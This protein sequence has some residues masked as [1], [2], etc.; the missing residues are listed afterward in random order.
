MR[1]PTLCCAGSL[2]IEEYVYCRSGILHDYLS[3]IHGFHVIQKLSACRGKD[4]MVVPKK[5]NLCVAF[6]LIIGEEFE[7]VLMGRMGCITEITKR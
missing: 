4:S 1:G 3:S 7:S 2:F 5:L 6:L